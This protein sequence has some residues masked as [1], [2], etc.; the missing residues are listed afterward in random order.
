MSPEDI[1]S[2]FADASATFPAIVGQPEDH[3]IH[4]LVEL[5][6][7]LLLDIPY[8][9]ENGKH[10]LVGLIQS[11]AV[12]KADYGA[13]F[14]RPGRVAAYPPEKG[15]TSIASDAHNA[16]RARAEA[17]WRAKRLDSITYDVTEKG[18]RKF[19][20]SKVEDTWIRELKSAK[21]FYTKVTARE[22]MMHLQ[23]ACLGTHAIDALSLQIAMRDYHH[24]AEGIPEYINMLEDAQRQALRINE[25]NPI[26]DASVLVIASAALLKDGRFA[27][28]SDEWENLSPQQKT[29]DAWKTMY[30]A[31]QG[32]ERVRVKAAG[33]TNAF[34]GNNEGSQAN[35]AE[36]QHNNPPNSD[37][38]AASVGDLE[39]CFDNLANAAKVERTT[40]D[41]LVKNN[42][43]LTT[44]NSEL[45]AANRE[46]AAENKKL[47]AE[48]DALRKAAKG[49]GG[50]NG[51][52]ERLTR[53]CRHCKGKC[54]G[55]PAWHK[56]ND[57]LELPANA[58]KRGA[59]WKSCL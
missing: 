32:K 5:L 23:Q 31:A 59:D 34:G 12:Y 57:C 21:Y 37:E 2:I 43:L 47:R 1:A 6:T 27:R 35:A 52:G 50:G 30:K 17:M 26:T 8:D 19:I 11:D 46:S 48:N 58:G 53:K 39:A 33:G 4:A 13:I 20:I 7:P 40:L 55:I 36:E 22:I 45:V 41:E 28:T 38:V 44:S 54:K 51:S 15:G 25:S 18:C 3:Q 29:W 49:N 42:G 56:D 16:V 9:A 10:S 14:V 24:T